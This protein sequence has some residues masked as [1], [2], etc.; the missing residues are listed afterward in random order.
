[1]II[2][3][4]GWRGVAIRAVAAIAFGVLTLVWPELTLWALVILFGAYVLVDGVFSLA[5]ASKP[6]GRAR[7]GW[8]VF[9]GIVGIAAGIVTFLWPDIT[10]L[11]L[12]Y[13]IAAWA[14]LS[15]VFRIAAAISQRRLIQNEWLLALTGA[16]SIVF[17]ILLVITP[18]AGALVITWLI[19]WFALVFGVLLLAL[20]L[21][22]RRVEHEIEGSRAVGTRPAPA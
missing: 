8:L 16:A 1:M 13:V 10:A 18:G 11:A 14:F 12:L 3:F 22:L 6:E 5:A 4:G 7:R 9:E 17:A 21:H 20:A 19:G 2:V 15:G